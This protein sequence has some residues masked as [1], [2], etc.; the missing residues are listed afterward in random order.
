MTCFKNPNFKRYFQ[1]K[2]IHKKILHPV[3]TSN[4]K[5]CSNF[6][7][8]DLKSICNLE[9]QIL[10]TT[11]SQQSA[12]NNK[13]V[14][15]NNVCQLQKYLAWNNL[16]QQPTFAT[17]WATFAITWHYAHFQWHYEN[18]VQP[19]DAAPKILSGSQS[20][21]TGAVVFSC[22]YQCLP[23]WYAFLILNI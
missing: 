3:L 1:F 10:Q 21:C 11:C 16:C 9:H 17:T 14:L 4:N 7:S 18:S 19:S 13:T 22:C 2:L 12:S 8:R 15:L 5:L 23:F 20:I 6:Q